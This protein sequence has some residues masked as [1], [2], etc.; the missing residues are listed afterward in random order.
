[1]TGGQIDADA[2]GPD[3]SRFR[4][5]RPF[6]A[7]E[8]RERN[9][10]LPASFTAT[11]H[12]P[13]TFRHWV[14]TLI[15]IAT[16]APMMRQARHERGS[17]GARPQQ[18]SLHNTGYPVDCSIGDHDFERNQTRV[19]DAAFAHDFQRARRGGTSREPAAVATITEG[20][21]H[22]KEYDRISFVTPVF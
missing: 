10:T 1:V 20:V 13:L 19:G 7:I 4:S 6:G 22:G 3:H 2:G 16:T 14:D 21:G 12:R 11:G 5:R 17:A 15:E 9:F 18:R 8:A